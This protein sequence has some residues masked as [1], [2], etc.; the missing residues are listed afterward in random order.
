ME[1]LQG[2]IIMRTDELGAIIIREKDLAQIKLE[3]YTGKE[4][5]KEHWEKI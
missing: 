5:T 2:K 3:R 1:G 4:R